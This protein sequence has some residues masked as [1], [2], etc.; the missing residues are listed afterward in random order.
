VPLVVIAVPLLV[1]L[2]PEPA[3]NVMDVT[4][5]VLSVFPLAR[6]YAAMALSYA[7][8]TAVADALIS[9]L[10]VDVLSVIPLQ[11]FTSVKSIVV[12]EVE[13]K[14]NDPIFFPA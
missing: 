5:P 14:E 8:L 7:D 1:I 2:I 11:V 13:F 3:V 12:F 9:L 4:V 6:L 10:V